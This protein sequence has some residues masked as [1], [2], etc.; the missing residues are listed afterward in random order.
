MEHTK[1]IILVEPRQLEKLKESILDKTISK[2]DGE[3]YEILHRNMADDEKAKLY[4]NSL[5]RY[6][7]LDK[8]SIVTKFTSNDDVQEVAASTTKDI[9]SMLL[10][11]V[12]KKWKSHASRL[13]T[14]IKSIP[15]I[16]WSDKGEMVLKNSVISKPH[17]VDLV[18]DLLRK[19][20]STSTTTGWKQ[21][22]DA[23]EEYNIPRELIGN[24]DRW[25]YINDTHDESTSVTPKRT[26]S[27]KRRRQRKRIDWEPY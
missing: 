25:N 17:I 27:G 6:L 2:L 11:T 19:R 16:R 23:L 3:F 18:N 24:V 8:P 7:T 5:S 12:R 9:E 26:A 1:K 13:L 21:L 15:G 22:A 4:S 20:T 14:H 10:D